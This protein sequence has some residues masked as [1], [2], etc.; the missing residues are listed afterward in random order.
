MIG[1]EALISKSKTNSASRLRRFKTN[2]VIL[3]IEL[4]TSHMWHS[5]ATLRAEPHA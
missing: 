4:F 1:I 2:Y 5:T 3:T